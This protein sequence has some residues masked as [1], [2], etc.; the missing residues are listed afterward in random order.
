[1]TGAPV[2]AYGRG[3]AKRSNGVSGS[4]YLV[5]IEALAGRTLCGRVAAKV[6]ITP[7]PRPR[8]ELCRACSKRE[9]PAYM[10]P[11]LGAL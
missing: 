6:N 5:H 10:P 2:R 7:D 3:M 11:V 9:D 4:N 1:M 8:E